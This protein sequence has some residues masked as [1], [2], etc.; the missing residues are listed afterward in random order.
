MHYKTINLDP[1]TYERLQAYKIG[2]M[3]FNDVIDNFIETMDPMEMYQ[4]F[5]EEHYRRLA[6][7]KA[8]EYDTLDDLKASLAS[9]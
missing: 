5:L 4:D 8:G 7:M 1:E 9:E 2:Q 6:R 3:T